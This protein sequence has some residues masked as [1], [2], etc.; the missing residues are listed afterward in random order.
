[1]AGLY[2]LEIWHIM[3]MNNAWFDLPFY[4]IKHPDCEIGSSCYWKWMYTW[5]DVFYTWI[6]LGSLILGISM[7]K[8]LRILKEKILKVMFK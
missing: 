4:I 8:P 1:M 5:R 6:I 7:Y 3:I 2:Q